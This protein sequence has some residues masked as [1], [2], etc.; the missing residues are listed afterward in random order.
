MSGLVNA[1]F[2]AYSRIEQARESG[3]VQ[4]GII[5]NDTRNRSQL[6]HRWSEDHRAGTSASE[7]G[8]MASLREKGNLLRGR[9][10]ERADLPHLRFGIS[11]DPAAELRGDLGQRE[12]PTHVCASYLLPSALITFSVM[13]MRGFA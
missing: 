12:R 10:F 9:M 1:G 4:N 3:K 11:N 6:L 13:S 5:G 2:T 7:F 8:N